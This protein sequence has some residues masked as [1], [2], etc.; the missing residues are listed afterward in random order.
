MAALPLEK[1][2]AVVLMLLLFCWRFIHVEKKM[3]F[4]SGLLESSY[5]KGSRDLPPPCLCHLRKD[6]K[7]NLLLSFKVR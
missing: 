5:R 7:R 1:V 3:K 2:L 4:I 6:E